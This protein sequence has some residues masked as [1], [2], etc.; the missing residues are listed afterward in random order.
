MP[1]HG[2][3]AARND[4]PVPPRRSFTH[5]TGY[6]IMVSH[7]VGHPGGCAIFK[8]ERDYPQCQA[9]RIDRVEADNGAAVAC[10][11]AIESPNGSLEER[12]FNDCWRT[13]E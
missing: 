6:E 9:D 2:H 1:G 4:D 8:D 13:S 10:E 3:N 12:L 11:T 5:S 7:G